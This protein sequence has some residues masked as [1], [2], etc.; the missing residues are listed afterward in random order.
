MRCNR[1][2]NPLQLAPRKQVIEMNVD[3]NYWAVLLAA[4]A[5]MIVGFVWYMALFSKPWTKEMG[6]SDKDMQAGKDKAGKM[7]GISFILSLLTAYILVHV[8]T[9]S[10]I[11]YHYTPVATGLSSAFWMWLGFIMPVQ[12]TDVMFGG[13][14][15]KLFAMNTGYQL[16]SL[17]AMGLVIGLMM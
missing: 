4:V 13:K 2:V 1:L 3:V 12:A 14:S 10:L 5:S 9:F 17:L 7:Y 11:F 16:A 6:I 8:M 15:F